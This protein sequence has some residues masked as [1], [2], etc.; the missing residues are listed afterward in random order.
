MVADITPS[1]FHV[2]GNPD[3]GFL[4]ANE[5]GWYKAFLKLTN[6]RERQKIADNAKGEFDRLYNPHDWARKLY[7][8]IQEI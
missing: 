1:H 8:N 7:M 6:Y 5:K 2:M 3:C 4:V